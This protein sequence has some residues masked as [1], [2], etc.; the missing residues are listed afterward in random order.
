[1]HSSGIKTLP[2]TTAIPSTSPAPHSS[3]HQRFRELHPVLEIEIRECYDKIAG[4]ESF[5]YLD[6]LAVAHCLS[7]EEMGN[8]IRELRGAKT[9]LHGTCYRPEV[10]VDSKVWQCLNDL[11]HVK[12]SFA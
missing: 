11:N 10:P 7:L 1:M 6:A 5:L 4:A 3:C 9:E 2:L 12:S 8:K